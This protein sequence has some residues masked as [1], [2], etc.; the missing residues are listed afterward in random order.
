MVRE[1][2]NHGTEVILGHNLQVDFSENMDKK[3]EGKVI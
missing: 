1:D 2:T 3:K